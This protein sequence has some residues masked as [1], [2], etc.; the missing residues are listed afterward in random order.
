MEDIERQTDHRE[1]V[2]VVG[3]SLE[4]M[5]LGL[6]LHPKY[7]TNSKSKVCSECV[8]KHTVTRIDGL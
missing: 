3:W 4:M 7:E 2:G 6:V 1:N 8:D 5:F